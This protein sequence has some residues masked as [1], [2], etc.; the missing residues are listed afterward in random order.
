MDENVEVAIARVDHERAL[1]EV[2]SDAI[3]LATGKR[4]RELLEP[5]SDVRLP[6]APVTNGCVDGRRL[7]FA[8]LAGATGRGTIIVVVLL[9][10][11]ALGRPSIWRNV[12]ISDARHVGVV[13]W[14]GEKMEREFSSAIYLSKEGHVVVQFFS[15]L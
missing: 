5:G 3:D 11:G 6:F 15:S 12:L 7:G 14:T 1:G 2:K 8:R 10:P 13:A 4:A 9:V